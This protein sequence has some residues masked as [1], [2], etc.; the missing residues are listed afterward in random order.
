MIR[1]ASPLQAPIDCKEL[2]VIQ[3]AKATKADKRAEGSHCNA[4]RSRRIL[5]KTDVTTVGI[6]VKRRLD[7]D[8]SYNQFNRNYRIIL[9]TYISAATRQPAQRAQNNISRFIV[10]LS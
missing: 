10:C 4:G 6:G 1:L 7:Q 9:T 8:F 5:W 3:T 2:S